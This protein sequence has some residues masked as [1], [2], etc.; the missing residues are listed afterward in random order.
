[1]MQTLAFDDPFL[2]AEMHTRSIKNAVWPQQVVNLPTDEQKLRLRIS[3]A[4]LGAGMSRFMALVVEDDTRQ[5][6]V[7]A[8]VLTL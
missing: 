6:E 5:R 8:D 2:C 4:R 7:L 3:P 1:M